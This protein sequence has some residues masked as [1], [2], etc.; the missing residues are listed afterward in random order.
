MRTS[1]IVSWKRQAMKHRLA[2]CISGALAI[3]GLIDG[4]LR[5]M[6]PKQRQVAEDRLTEM[7]GSI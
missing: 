3:E 4:A 5:K 6:T 2:G 1:R 7:E